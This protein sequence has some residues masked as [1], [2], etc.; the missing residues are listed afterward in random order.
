MG[1]YSFNDVPASHVLGVC[2]SGWGSVAGQN[3]LMLYMAPSN[4]SQAW[5]YLSQ[6]VLSPTLSMGSNISNEV[7]KKYHL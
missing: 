1:V 3:Y 2:T 4:T 6:L 7:V 5:Y